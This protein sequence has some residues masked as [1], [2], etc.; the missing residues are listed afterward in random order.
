MR[1]AGTEH[2]VIPGYKPGFTVAAS[3]HGRTRGRHSAAAA[4]ERVTADL[5]NAEMGDQARS[6]VARRELPAGLVRPTGMRTAVR[7]AGPFVPVVVLAAALLVLP[8]LATASGGPPPTPVTPSAAVDL[9]LAAPA[10]MPGALEPALPGTAPVP[11]P[12]TPAKAAETQS[13][14]DPDGPVSS[15][16]MP[17]DPGYWTPERTANAKPMPMPTPR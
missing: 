13:P 3:Q 6:K 7:L 4:A 16:A 2:D 15:P 8:G 5:L 17:S 12:A 11:D 10:L 14:T 1:D 9:P